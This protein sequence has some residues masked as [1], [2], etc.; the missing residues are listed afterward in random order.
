MIPVS[1][2][3][4]FIQKKL[5]GLRFVGMDQNPHGIRDLLA[6]QIH[7]VKRMEAFIASV[8]GE[9]DD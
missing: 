9:H 7:E 6:V 4:E 3:L 2:E 8:K 5:D 1:K